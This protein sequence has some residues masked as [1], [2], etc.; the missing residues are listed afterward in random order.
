MSILN[1][2]LAIKERVLR[3]VVG[4]F[5]TTIK[6]ISL[7]ALALTILFVLINDYPVASRW[8]SFVA[9][10]TLSMSGAFWR[11][12]FT[13]AI[14]SVILFGSVASIGFLASCKK[15][16]NESEKGFGIYIIILI[17]GM[18]SAVAVWQ[19]TTFDP[20]IKSTLVLLSIG[21]SLIALI[22]CE[23]ADYTTYNRVS[24]VWVKLFAS[25]TTAACMVMSSYA[26]FLKDFKQEVMDK[27]II[28]ESGKSYNTDANGNL[29][30]VDAINTEEVK[31]VMGE[32]ELAK[33][34]L[35]NA[36][37]YKKILQAK[38]ETGRKDMTAISQA[39]ANYSKR[40]KWADY[41]IQKEKKEN[42][43]AQINDWNAA[44]LDAKSQ[45]ADKKSTIKALKE[46]LALAKQEV[47]S[48]N[49]EAIK[50][51]DKA[52]QSLQF[53]G[54]IKG[55]SAEFLYTFLLFVVLRVY[56]LKPEPNNISMPRIN[57][58]NFQMPRFNRTA[59]NDAP[60]INDIPDVDEQPRNNNR[61]NRRN[62][63]RQHENVG[64]LF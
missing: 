30:V 20:Q 56:S 10:D 58:P 21:A 39:M 31:Y 29:V 32:L 2:I 45:V 53:V 63:N 41:N 9:N 43:Q 47:G 15:P 28:T 55:V 1:S 33:S 59:R 48:N 8:A 24:I 6:V 60:D 4:D 50:K 42:L 18:T 46:E 13:Y 22:W 52:Y 12:F 57:M 5:Q 44:L 14:I 34:D 54:I 19:L 3:V 40:S 27:K 17:A 25:L 36:E 37:A 64:E 35:M 38:I 11:V 16:R 62:R 61:R 26:F 7:F 23:T 49:H 51:Y